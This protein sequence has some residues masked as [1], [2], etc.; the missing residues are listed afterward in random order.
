M[1]IVNKYRSILRSSVKQLIM[2]RCFS[3]SKNTILNEHESIIQSEVEKAFKRK[4]CL[5]AI[6]YYT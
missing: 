5:L 4:S 1:L 6:N 3:N 2:R